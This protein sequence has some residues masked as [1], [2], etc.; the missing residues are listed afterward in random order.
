MERLMS[1]DTD[2]HRPRMGTSTISLHHSFL[3][4]EPIREPAQKAGK[5]QECDG[6]IGRQ[7]PY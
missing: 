6:A 1:V 2:D 5:G 7:G 4:V 3:P